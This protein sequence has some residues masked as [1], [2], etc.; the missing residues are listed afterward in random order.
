VV[1][2]QLY[3]KRAGKRNEDDGNRSQIVGINED[4]G[5]HSER[6]ARNTQWAGAYMR[7][8]LPRNTAALLCPVE[9][10]KDTVSI[11]I[12]PLEVCHCLC[13]EG[14]FQVNT[15]PIMFDTNLT[16]FLNEYSFLNLVCSI[17]V[18][19]NRLCI[20]HSVPGSQCPKRLG[21]QRSFLV[22]IRKQPVQ[23]GHA[24]GT[25]YPRRQLLGFWVVE[26]IDHD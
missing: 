25:Y 5:K 12:E 3:S 16:Q 17:A 9:N 15:K 8:T 19:I 26:S 18:T 14:H 13:H 4:R 24:S 10:N 11:V 22:C 2:G 7:P 20:S 23:A 1:G 6:A 21:A